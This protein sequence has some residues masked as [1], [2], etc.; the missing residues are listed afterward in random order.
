MSAAPRRPGLLAVAGTGQVSGAERVL[1][2][3]VEAALAA[4]WRVVCAAPPGPLTERLAEA[5][6]EVVALPELGLA[7]GS[8]P[9]ALART[10][11][12]WARAARRL[13]RASRGLDV[14][15]LNAWS[16][17]PA[18]RLAWPRRR[19]HPAPAVAWLAHDVLTRPDRVQVFAA[20]RGVLT[21]VLA[22]SEAV[23]RPL[24]GDPPA[25]VVHNGVPWPVE[26]APDPLSADP[27]AP[28]VV[29]INALLS[30]WKGHR[31]LL[32]AAEHLPD[33]VVVEVMGGHLA[34]D[35]DYAASLR[36]IVE[37]SPRLRERVRLLGH[38]ADP[39]ARMRTWTVAV[40]ASTQPEACPLNVLEAMSI[41]VPVVASD[42]G[43][44]PEV[45]A[46]S[47]VLVPPD[48]APALAAA[49]TDLLDDPARRAELARRGRDR[50]ATAHRLDRQTDRLL[51]ELARLAGL[52]DPPTPT[53]PHGRPPMRVLFVNENIGGHTTVH[54][55]LR[56]AF[57]GHP[58]VQA[59]FLDVPAPSLARRVLGVRVPG[60]AGLDADLQPLRAQLALSAW[61]RRHL[62]A[63]L[64]GIDVLH[65]YT[66]NAGLRSTSVI[67]SMASVVSTDATNETNAY[68]LPSRPATR[69][70]PAT[71]RLTKRWERPVYEAA[72][73]VAPSTRWVADSLRQHYGVPDDKVRVMPF[74]IAAPEYGPGPAPGTGVPE[75][76]RLPQLV[77]VGRSLE[78]KGGLRLL[79]LHQEHLADL[80]ELVLVT[81]EDPPAG[82]NVRVVRDVTVET[83]GVWPLL[84]EAAVFAFPSVIDQAPNV[85]I[86]AQAAGLPVVGVRQGAMDEMVPP[87]TGV[88]VEAD[89]DAGLVAAL[90]R[91][92]D[93]PDLRARMGTAARQRFLHTYDIRVTVPALV[94]VLREAHD[95]HHGPGS[96]RRS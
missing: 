29:G 61:V 83:G 9:V 64:D 27:D 6:A 11:A 17:L 51:A 5:G 46:G 94:A 84:R 13:R 85:V 82:R 36:A 71:V 1:V 38:V 41:G 67:A 54:A 53:S 93:E 72:T 20:C 48:D 50:V 66:G 18:A 33:D 87:E 24:R 16:A 43:G 8:R 35:G 22:V 96:G 28:R 2:R 7:A 21:R 40:S 57:V 95:R 68:R 31:V 86:E 52:P 77:F 39:L 56:T 91:L 88:L 92:V 32:E 70:T 79:R 60:L 19:P 10:L 14:V 42:H 69:L 45:L 37:A 4:G 81:P 3:A 59:E 74:G 26:P 78:R 58:E 12:R 25:T 89:D 44:S 15:L 76:G 49:L 55:H 63:R 65:V 34:K 23:A 73:L 47:G 30:P 90:R 80:C 75:D 62:V